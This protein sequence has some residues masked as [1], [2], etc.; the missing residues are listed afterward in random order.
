MKGKSI[1]GWNAKD[2]YNGNTDAIGMSQHAVDQG[3]TALLIKVADGTAN[4][5]VQ[6]IFGTDNILGPITDAFHLAGREVWGWQFCYG[7]IP[8]GEAIKAVE[9]ITKFG[10]DGFVIDAE[11]QFEI[12]NV[13]TR[14]HLYL[15]KLAALMPP[16]IP[17]GLTTFRYP[18]VHPKFPWEIYMKWSRLKF[19]M[20]QVYWPLAHNPGDQLRESLKQYREW[21]TKF[22]VEPKPFYPI[23]AAFSQKFNDIPWQPSIG[24]MQEFHATVLELGLEVES[25]WCWDHSIRL[26][27]EP[28]LKS[29]TFPIPEPPPDDLQARIAKLEQTISEL[30]SKVAVLENVSTDTG[31]VLVDLHE[32]VREIQT[33]GEEFP[34]KVVG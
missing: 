22:G 29:F 28:T 6:P 5:N 31:I 12:D 20:P 9:R 15:D 17:I 19:Y 11:G 18:N 1:Y 25:W 30:Q 2:I 32:A 26:G 7:G 8:E 10:M 16:E 21:E 4:H 13:D 27:Y 33:W 14:V 34:K 24:E 3:Y 23:G